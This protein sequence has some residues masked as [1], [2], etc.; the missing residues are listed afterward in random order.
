MSAVGGGAGNAESRGPGGALHEGV[1]P[2]LR[3]S[4]V[5]HF[6]ADWV[7]ALPLFFFP[8]AFLGALGWA[9]PDAALARVVA[10]ALIGIGTQSLLDRNAS[11]EAYKS[12][13]GLKVLWSGSA[14]LG[15]LWSALTVGPPMV[16]GFV[17]IFATFNSLWCYWRFR[18]GKLL[19]S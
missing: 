2:A 13:L 12:L 15:L 1:P 14:T 6:F 10:A 16:W 18:V 7:F 5:M 3:F 11:L 8:E 17:L 9:H 19:A 4:F